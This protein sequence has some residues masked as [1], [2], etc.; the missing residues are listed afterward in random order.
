M[1]ELWYL[2][3]IYSEPGPFLLA[4]YF[5]CIIS[6]SALNSSKRQMLLSSL[7]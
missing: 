2:L 5:P 4:M 6:I 7:V 1:G 3:S